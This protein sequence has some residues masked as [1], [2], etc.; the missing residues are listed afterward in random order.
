MLPKLGMSYAECEKRIKRIQV[1]PGHPEAKANLINSLR[2]QC[3][4]AEGESALTDLDKNCHKEGSA[5]SGAGPKQ[6]GI[7]SGVKLGV[8]RWRYVQGSWV[9][10]S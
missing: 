1:N 7:G 4:L 2:N 6:I 9:Q 8:G 3:R 10:I 5:F